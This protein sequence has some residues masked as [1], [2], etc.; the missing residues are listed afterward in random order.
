MRR[1]RSWEEAPD[2]GESFAYLLK[3]RG[4][5][6]PSCLELEVLPKVLDPPCCRGKLIVGFIGMAERC[7][8]KIAVS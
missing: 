4:I 5:R 6:M 3:N 8:T 2:G 7:C 1:A